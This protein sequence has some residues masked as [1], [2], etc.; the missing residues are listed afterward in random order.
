MRP[1]QVPQKLRISENFAKM[2]RAGPD[3]EPFLWQMWSAALVPSTVRMHPH[4]HDAWSPSSWCTHSYCHL[5][6]VIMPS[7]RWCRITFPCQQAPHDQFPM[8]CPTRSLTV[9]IAEATNAYPA[10]VR[11]DFIPTGV[12]RYRADVSVLMS[13]LECGAAWNT[14]LTQC[15]ARV[16]LCY[17]NFVHT[18][19]LRGRIVSAVIG[20]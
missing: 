11:P 20:K 4:M 5:S 16:L 8:E 18:F 14:R 6:H 12:I 13:A 15:T 10:A 3:G 19:A 17:G 7:Q 9:G 1:Q 2:I